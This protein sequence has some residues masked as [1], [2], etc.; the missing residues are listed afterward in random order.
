MKRNVVQ[1]VVGLMLTALTAACG[2]KND[3][4][5]GGASSL[6][7]FDQLPVVAE[8]VQLPDGGSI[9]VA[10]PGKAGEK[11]TLKLSDLADDLKIVR[12]ENSDDALVGAGQTWITGERIIVYSDGVV[13]QFDFEGKC[14]GQIG[15]K[16]NGPGEYSI[17]PYDFYVDADAG[18]IYM[19]QYN[20]TKLMSYNSDG[21]FAGDIP[22]AREMPKGAVRVDT[23][24]QR[25]TAVSICF[26]GSKSRDEV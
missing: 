8:R 20:A 24:R 3:N 26:E 13:K 11:V 2:A 6:A 7:A 4:A 21:T 18:R 17:A 15:A 9:V 12:L 16:G 14:L 1:P 22:L 19:V 10:D 25:I 23:K 5:A